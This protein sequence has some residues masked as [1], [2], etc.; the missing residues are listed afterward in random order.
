MSVEKDIEQ[1]KDD[2]QEHQASDAKYYAGFDTEI[3][4]IKTDIKKIRENHLEHIQNSVG[5]LETDVGWIKS[6]FEQ[7][8]YV[9]KSEFSV[10]KKLVYGAVTLILVGFAGV[11]GQVIIKVLSI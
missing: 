9:K 11:V 4:E 7:N 8:G 6:A 5:K 1:I 3:K 10:I 2:L